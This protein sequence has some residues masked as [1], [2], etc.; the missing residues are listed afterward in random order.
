MT[1]PFDFVAEGKTGDLEPSQ[2]KEK[3]LEWAEA[4]ATWW[5]E[6]L[7]EATPEQASMRLH[8]GPPSG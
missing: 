4:G 1:T 5:V 3:I 7:W 6:G 2:V 8:Q